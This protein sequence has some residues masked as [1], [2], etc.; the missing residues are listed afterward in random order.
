MCQVSCTEE[1]TGE[2]ISL[3]MGAG[4]LNGNPF[5]GGGDSF[6]GMGIIAGSKGEENLLQ[7]IAGC[8]YLP[9]GRENIFN[10]SRRKIL[11]KM[12]L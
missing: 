10:G 12:C 7:M 11:P 8:N 6:Q 2:G 9:C 4:G 5:K 3:T 1:V